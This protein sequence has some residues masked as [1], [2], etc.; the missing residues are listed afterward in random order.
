MKIC[1][2]TEVEIVCYY[3]SYAIFRILGVNLLIVVNN[4]VQ[5]SLVNDYIFV[6]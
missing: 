4:W 1:Q 2:K 5:I 3:Q 6:L